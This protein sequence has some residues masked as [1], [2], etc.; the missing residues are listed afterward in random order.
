MANLPLCTKAEYRF[1]RTSIYSKNSLETKEFLTCLKAYS[2]LL[3]SI[4]TASY[5][6]SYISNYH[7]RLIYRLYFTV[8]QL[9]FSP[10][11]IFESCS[12]KQ[13]VLNRTM[14]SKFCFDSFFVV[15]SN[16]FFYSSFQFFITAINF[17]IVHFLL[18]D[19]KEIFHR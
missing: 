6:C 11:F 9:R 19:S 17:S 15:I 16:I 1:K 14:P 3:L 13:S 8:S 18:Q 4:G 10:F 5:G 7:R 2:I 12:I